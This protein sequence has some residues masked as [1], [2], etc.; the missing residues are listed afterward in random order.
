MN[1]FLGVLM[2]ETHRKYSLKEFNFITSK[3]TIVKSQK[4]LNNGDYHIWKKKAK[5]IAKQN[6]INRP[7]PIHLHPLQ[8]FEVI[9]KHKLLKY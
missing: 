2:V 5:L 9:S 6:L 8:S 3:T 7:Q 1:S 4:N